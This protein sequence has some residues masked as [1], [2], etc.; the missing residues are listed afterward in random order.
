MNLKRP[1]INSTSLP[2]LSPQLALE[3]EEP[4]CPQLYLGLN[5][6]VL[7]HGGRQ[8]RQLV[9]AVGDACC[10]PG[11]GGGEGGYRSTLDIWQVFM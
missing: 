2:H 4:Q 6:E 11:E 7:S 8:G 1:L 9:N 10:Q 3:V 5:L